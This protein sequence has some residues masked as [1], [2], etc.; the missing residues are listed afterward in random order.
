MTCYNPH[1]N[2][3]AFPIEMCKKKNACGLNCQYAGA[4][5]KQRINFMWPNSHKYRNNPIYDI[6]IFMYIN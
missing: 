2:Y 1:T 5:E 4:D 3:I 6:M